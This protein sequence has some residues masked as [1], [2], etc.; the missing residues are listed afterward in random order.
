MQINRLFEIIYILLE[1]KQITA[2][3]LAKRFEV[4]TRTIYRDVETLSAAGIPIYMKKGKTGGISLLPNFI[5]N[6]TILTE[7]EK[8]EIL[9]SMKAVQTIDLSKSDNALKKLS[10]LL[11]E[12]HSD[13]I[14]VDFSFWSDTKS[15]T[16][17]FIALKS[18]I[19]NKQIISFSYSGARHG[20]LSR[21][22]EPLK[23]CFKGT[24]WYLYAYCLKRQDFRFFKLSRIKNLNCLKEYFQRPTPA[25]IFSEPPLL[26]APIIHLKLKISAKMSYR[27]YDEFDTYSQLNDGSF[28]VETDVPDGEWIF[29]YITSYGTECEVLSPNEIRNKIKSD[30]EIVLSY[31]N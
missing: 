9:S 14:E 13:W 7:H 5:L 4:S 26:G 19:L 25:Q 16:Q 24:S 29:S 8:Q 1:K 3:E 11:G 23:L 30:L 20:E 27:V 15:Q 10:S 21:K 31:Y 17:T 6:K 2:R 28:L 12:H 22:A 18:A